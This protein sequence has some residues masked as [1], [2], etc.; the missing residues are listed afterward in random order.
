LPLLMFSDKMLFSS[1]LVYL[2]MMFS[3]KL[4]MWY[5]VN[6]GTMFCLSYFYMMCTCC[7]LWY[8]IYIIS[9]KFCT[10]FLQSATHNSHQLMNIKF[11]LVGLGWRHYKGTLNLCFQFDIWTCEWIL[12][13]NSREL[14]QI[15]YKLQRLEPN[16]KK[17]AKTN[18]INSYNC[19][20]Q[21]HI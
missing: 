14:K 18:A 11:M 6:Y 21:L 16:K 8:S 10:Y 15:F 17:L 2:I 3:F 9:F 20:D 12:M 19:R 1:F 5:Y 7:T 13:N 4:N